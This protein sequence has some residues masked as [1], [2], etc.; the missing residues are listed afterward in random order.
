MN[1]VEPLH[2]KVE[3]GRDAIPVHKGPLQGALGDSD[4]EPDF[5]N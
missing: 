5:F 1:I 2:L 4:I 3:F